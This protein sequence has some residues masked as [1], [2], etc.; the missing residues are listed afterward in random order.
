M[1]PDLNLVLL[2]LRVLDRNGKQLVFLNGWQGIKEND[3]LL[4]QIG[5][6]WIKFLDLILELD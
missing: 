4:S 5:R 6:L 3:E 2:L 1:R